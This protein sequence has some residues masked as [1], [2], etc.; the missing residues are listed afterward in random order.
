MRIITT[1]KGNRKVSANELI[2]L[3]LPLGAFFFFSFF[4]R[5]DPLDLEPWGLAS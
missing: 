4:Q 3:S 1:H 5:T 2:F